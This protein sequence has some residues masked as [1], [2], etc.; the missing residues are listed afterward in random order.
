M[1][2]FFSPGFSRRAAI[3]IGGK[4]PPPLPHWERIPN[5]GGGLPPMAGGWVNKAVKA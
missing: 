1:R 2:G 3:A 5:V 4:R